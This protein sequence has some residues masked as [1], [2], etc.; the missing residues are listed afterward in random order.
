MVS[1][2]AENGPTPLAFPSHTVGL[3]DTSIG[4]ASPLG[5]RSSHQ[6]AERSSF[7]DGERATAAVGQAAP[8]RVGPEAI[9]EQLRRLR[10][11]A[12]LTQ[13]LLAERAGVSARTVSDL[14]RG[15]RHFPYRETG[16]RLADALGL[17]GQERAVFHAG[18]R[19]GRLVPRRSTTASDGRP[20]ALMSPS[21]LPRRHVLAGS[22]HA[23]SKA[24]PGDSG[25]LHWLRNDDRGRCRGWLCRTAAAGQ[26]SPAC[27]V[28]RAA[29]S[30][31]AVT[32]QCE[33]S[34]K[35]HAG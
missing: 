17:E 15:V 28:R 32:F 22:V 7:V 33:G 35:P 29:R 19:L 2:A 27:D 3:R 31:S 25:P 11:Q 6:P 9:G 8:A 10:I 12:G 34:R 18:P 14:E 13:D 26:R 20:S 4:I 24:P 16:R 1:A 5:G 23:V 30:S 21:Q